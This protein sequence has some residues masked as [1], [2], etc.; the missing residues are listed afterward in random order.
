MREPGV[1]DEAEEGGRLADALVGAGAELLDQA[2][3]QQLGDEVA[4]W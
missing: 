4:R 2:L 1:G 3:G